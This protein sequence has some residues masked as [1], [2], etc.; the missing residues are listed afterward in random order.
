MLGGSALRFQYIV[1]RT[2]RCGNENV[3]PV[4]FPD[5]SIGLGILMESSF[6]SV[7]FCHGHTFPDDGPFDICHFTLGGKVFNP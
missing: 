1:G 2:Y 3:A 4:P 7:W 6:P 5:S